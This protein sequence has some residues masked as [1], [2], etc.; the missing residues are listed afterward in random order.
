[1]ARA[2]LGRKPKGLHPWAWA[3]L[4]GQVQVGELTRLACQRSLRDHREGKKRGIYFDP[5]AAEHVLEFFGYLRHS[6]G[7]WAGEPFELQPWQEFTLWELFGW[8]RESGGRRFREAYEEVGRKNG[9]TTMLAA[10]GLY[11]V[12]GDGEPWR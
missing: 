7:R 5:T 3:V 2:N 6:K 11:M 9:K 8:Q 1:M 4:K 10:I 12:A